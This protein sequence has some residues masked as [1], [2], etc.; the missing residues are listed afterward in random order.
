MKAKLFLAAAAIVAVSATAQAQE[1]RYEFEKAVI[2]TKAEMMGQ[3]M[4][5]TYY[6]DDY[7]KKEASEFTMDMSAM[8]GN[9]MQ[10]RSVR[11]ADGTVTF[12]V[13]NVKEGH[14]SEGTVNFLN[15]TPEVIKKH[16]I[17]EKGEEV[18]DGRPCK[19]YTVNTEQMGMSVSSTV[20]VWKGFT[21]KTVV[22]GGMFTIETKLDTFDENGKIPDGIFTIP[23]GMK[24]R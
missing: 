6:I 7:G 17:K 9:K 23:D 24:I 14:K 12:D 4:V 13:N 2:T 21:V 20:W 22:D 18:I 1:A 3:P 5:T 15:L 10:M 11:Q 16:K 8:G 19:I